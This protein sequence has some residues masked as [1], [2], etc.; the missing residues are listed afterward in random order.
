[1]ILS[2][3]LPAGDRRRGRCVAGAGAWPAYVRRRAAAGGASSA[4][5]PPRCVVGWL[6]HLRAAGAR[7]RRLRPGRRPA[8]ASASAPVLSITVWLVIAVHTV[9]SRFVP[10]PAVRRCA[11]AGRRG[12][13]G[14]GGAVSRASCGR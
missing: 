1:M 10:L 5:R 13:G 2:T 4:G 8:R 12:R 9:E 14:A 3:C 11:G 7:H 6:L